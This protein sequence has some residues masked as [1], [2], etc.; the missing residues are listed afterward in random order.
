MP[1]SARKTRRQFLTEKAMTQRLLI[2]KANALTNPLE[3]LHKFHE[4]IT[5]DNKMIK[6]ACVK[7]KDATSDCLSWILDIMERNMKKMYEQ[8]S[9]GWNATEKQTE[10][11]EEMA[12]YL[13][14]SCD[15]KFLGFSH[16]R[17]D[18]DNGDVVLYCYELQL[19]PSTRRKGLG[20]FMMSTLESMA[21]HNQMMKVVLT[22]FKHNSSAIQFF[23]ALGY[24]LDNSYP[25]VSDLDYI[26]LS[27]QNLCE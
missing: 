21:Y 14:A 18:I 9:W 27:K 24:K 5:K 22:V 8:S 26:I 13:V 23:Y 1:K 12:W 17:F 25:P 7:A 2:N 6:L 3:T 16:F 15:D 11:T 19:E 20:R 10:L 4:Y